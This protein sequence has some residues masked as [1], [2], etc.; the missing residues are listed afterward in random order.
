MNRRKRETPRPAPSTPRSIHLQRLEARRRVPETSAAVSRPRKRAQRVGAEKAAS[1]LPPSSLHVGPRSLSF[2]FGRPCPLLFFL[3]PP[4]PNAKK[5]ASRSPTLA[6]FFPNSAHGD[7]VHAS[8]SIFS[9]RENT[10]EEGSE[11]EGEREK[12]GVPPLL[13]HHG[14]RSG[15]LRCPPSTEKTSLSLSLSLSPHSPRARARPCRRWE[16]SGR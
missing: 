4:P 6:L 8:C 13:S 3:P 7:Q 16:R 14:R 15:Q 5:E 11:R 1:A 10:K 12:G 9:G 2:S